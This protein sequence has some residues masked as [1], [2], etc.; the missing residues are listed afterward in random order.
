MTESASGAVRS[1]Q[2]IAAEMREIARVRLAFDPMRY[3]T[4]KTRAGEAWFD[5][6]SYYFPVGPGAGF[7]LRAIMYPGYVWVA[8]R[9][10]VV[11]SQAGVIGMQVDVDNGALPFLVVPRL[12][13]E[14]TFNW[15][16]TLPFALVVKQTS[17]IS[18]LNFDA[19]AQWIVTEWYG[20]W[21]AADVWQKDVVA[22]ERAAGKYSI[23]PV[24][25]AG[26]W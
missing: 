25:E 20:C 1:L 5:R 12:F 4:R 8:V 11:V 7:A 3:L 21:V 24:V 13:S 18:F 2:E 19:V 15:A 6:G 22:M 23:P 16:E 14:E 26:S 17:L 9:Q 10:R